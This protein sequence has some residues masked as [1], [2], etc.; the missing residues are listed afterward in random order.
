[1]GSS[2]KPN[3]VNSTVRRLNYVR[4]IW[5]HLERLGVLIM[6]AI[7]RGLTDEEYQEFMNTLAMIGN[8]ADNL[9]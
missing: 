3:G 4:L 1:M 2:S 8:I 7:N 5:A 9:R 6:I